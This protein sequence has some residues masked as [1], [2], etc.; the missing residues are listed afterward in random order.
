MTIDKQLLFKEVKRSYELSRFE[1]ALW[2]LI[3]VVPLL[4]CSVFIC[5][6]LVLSLLLGG[7]LGGLLIFAKWRGQQFGK[8]VLPGMVIG[9]LAYS[10][11]FLWMRF[12]A[13]PSEMTN[14]FVTIVA[15]ML[16]GAGVIAFAKSR[17]ELNSTFIVTASVVVALSGCLSCPML[18]N[19]SMI[20][21]AAGVLGVATLFLAVRKVA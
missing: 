10:I 15:G 4:I 16:A 17:G 12:G 1:N 13:M 2:T 7:L 18:G 20:G 9:F 6:S 14:L 21:M 11:P 3:F 8:A 5:H 19:L